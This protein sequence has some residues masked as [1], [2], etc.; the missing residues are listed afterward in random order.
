MPFPKAASLGPASQQRGPF[1][2]G[3]GTSPFINGSHLCN[4]PRTGGAACTGEAFWPLPEDSRQADRAAPLNPI[5]EPSLQLLF[6]GGNNPWL[7]LLSC[8]DSG[9]TPENARGGDAWNDAA[10][11]ITHRLI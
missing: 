2:R 3:P 6:K 9:V 10:T 7:E 11:V 5:A 4:F 8:A 1:S